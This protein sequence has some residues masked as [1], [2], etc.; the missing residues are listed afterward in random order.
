MP[1]GGGVYLI[2]MV[3]DGRVF[4]WGIGVSGLLLCAVVGGLWDCVDGLF[5]VVCAR[6]LR[7]RGC[8][9]EGR[10]PTEG[11]RLGVFRLF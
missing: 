1:E 10:F 3:S 11:S 5:G 9:G 4:V 7:R 6:G 2:C 8:R